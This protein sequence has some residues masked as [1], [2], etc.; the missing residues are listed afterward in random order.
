[1]QALMHKPPPTTQNPDWE[2][3]NKPPKPPPTIQEIAT[4]NQPL[5]TQKFNSK[6]QK[7]K[8][9]NPKLESKI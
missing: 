3:K 9:K 6:S 2:G 7:K 4:Q 8:R 5:T 1:M